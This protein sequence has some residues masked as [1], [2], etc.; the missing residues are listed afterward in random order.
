MLVEF[1]DKNFL[2]N[3]FVMT[4]S[5]ETPNT[6]SVSA[7][8]S[9]TYYGLSYE[10]GAWKAKKFETEDKAYSLCEFYGNINKS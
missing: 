2:Q 10:S 4:G 5:T 1:L 7:D 6:L 9:G 8:G 3:H